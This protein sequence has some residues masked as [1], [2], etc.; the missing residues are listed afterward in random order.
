MGAYPTV[1]IYLFYGN[2][3]DAVLKARDAVLDAVLP[4]AER[5]E[6]LTE[7]Y[8][9]AAGDKVTLA[10]LIDEIA[11]DMATVSF[12]PGACK[13]AVVTNPAE[14]FGG[15]GGGA[16]KPKGKTKGK[17]KADGATKA[18]QR[19]IY[20]I[21][22]EL[23]QTHDHL[24]LLAF[25]DESSMREVNQ[26]SPLYQSIQKVGYLR[27]FRDTKAFF[28]IEDAIL[29]RRPGECVAALRNLWKPGKGDS[30][31]YGCV[32]RC[33]RYILQANIA[34]ER[35]AMRDAERQAEFFPT[36]PRRNLFK[37]SPNVRRKYTSRA[38]YR[39]VDVLEAYDRLLDVY[40]A[41]RPRPGDVYVPDARGLLEQ[42]LLKLLTAP[43]P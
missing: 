12:I 30:S 27:G 6:N 13:C 23:P 11:G 17:A 9:T 2:Q 21:E 40:R 39:T 18:R 7:Y 37:A 8:P 16:K 15:G 22:N 3:A 25:E 42:T 1:P 32:V 29:A 43:R 35:G 33:L 28:R 19:M 26:K 5:N 24:I 31:V 41:L 20:W 34:R 4:P 38:I 36:D 14:L 10:A